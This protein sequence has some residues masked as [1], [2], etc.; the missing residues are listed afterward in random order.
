ML[1]SAR[2]FI[3][4]PT[5]YGDISNEGPYCQAINTINDNFK[6]FAVILAVHVT[7]LQFY[8]CML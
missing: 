8:Q 1:A 2:T 6:M 3:V 7:V 4:V 5:T